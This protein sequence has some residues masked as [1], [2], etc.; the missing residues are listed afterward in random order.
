MFT[1]AEGVGGLEFILLVVA[2]ASETGG[3]DT[4]GADGAAPLTTSDAEES[5]RGRVEF[6]WRTRGGGSSA[7][8]GFTATAPEVGWLG[9]V[10]DVVG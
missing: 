6:L 4:D 1:I 2:G 3:V 7:D 10:G 8:G 5:R 9:M